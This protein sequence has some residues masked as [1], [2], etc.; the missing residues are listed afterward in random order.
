MCK[1]FIFLFT[2]LVVFLCITVSSYALEYSADTIFTANGQKIY[3]KMY[4]KA[5]RFRM[6]IT[7]PQSMITITRMDK[8][9]VWSIIPS[10]KMYI[11][12]PF[13]PKTAPKTKISG[14]IDRKL[15]GSEKIDGHPTKK[16]LITYKEGGRTEKIYQWWATDINFPVKSAD[17]NNRWVQEYKNVKMGPQPN[18]L[19]EIPAGYSKMQMPMMPGGMKFEY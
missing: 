10:E 8:N 19:F 3:G 17:L 18:K 12:M 9:I 15:V 6:E 14:E 1:R 2:L 16:Y 5:D 11:E 13:D 4:V 7:K